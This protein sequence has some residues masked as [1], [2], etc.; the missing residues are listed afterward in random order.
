MTDKQTK[1]YVSF[2]RE[3][4]RTHFGKFFNF[5]KDYFLNIDKRIEIDTA[6]EKKLYQRF[7]HLGLGSPDPELRAHLGFDDT[8]N[9]TAMFGGKVSFTSNYSWLEPNTLIS[10]EGVKNLKVPKI[11]E[12]WPQTIF[13]EQFDKCAKTYG[14]E[15]IRTPTLHGVM[16]SALDLRG[17]DFLVDLL[18]RPHL[19]E[20]LLDVLTETV[21]RLKEFWDKKKYRKVRR[22]IPLGGCS[23][24]VLSPQSFRNYILPRYNFLTH[25]FGGGYL[26]ACGPDTHLL[27]SLRYLEDCDVYRLGWETDFRKAR[28]LL[29]NRHIRATLDPMRTSR[30][31]PEQVEKD[32]ARLLKE[33]GDPGALSL[34]LV[35]AAAETPEENITTIYSTVRKYRG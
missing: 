2:C 12:S 27:G 26:C 13:I 35:N 22:G 1:V 7:G 21:V 15:M 33:A 20:K 9:I 24:T 34:C 5:D 17:E 6:Q 19:A 11:E 14:T 3:Y 31:E 16:E 29:G 32:V 30:G 4:Y 28:Q 10:E 23:I 18:Q 8:L 25:R